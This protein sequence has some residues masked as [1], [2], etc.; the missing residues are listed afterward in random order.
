ME[1]NDDGFIHPVFHDV[2]LDLG[3]TYFEFENGFLEFLAWQVI[4]FTFIMIE[5]SIYW[6]GP[7]LLTDMAGPNI[8]RIMYGYQ[9]PWKIKTPIDV[10]H[11]KGDHKPYALM[12]WDLRNTRAPV[13]ANGNIDLFLMGELKYMD[14]LETCKYDPEYMTFADP[15]GDRT[16]NSQL[17][18]SENMASCSLNALARSPIGGMHVSTK[19]LNKAFKMFPKLPKFK[20]DSTSFGEYMPLFK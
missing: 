5:N 7:F 1:I 20:M 17:V 10:E 15:V 13:V 6:V 12:H 9:V 18:L 11:L 3:G 2:S 16:T 4:N 14:V 19:T 8:D